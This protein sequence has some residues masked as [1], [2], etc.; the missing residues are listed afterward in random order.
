[1]PVERLKQNRDMLMVAG[2][3]AMLATIADMFRDTVGFS[4]NPIYLVHVLGHI[5]FFCAAFMLGD[6]LIDR[7]LVGRKGTVDVPRQ[8]HA[9]WFDNLCDMAFS[10]IPQTYAF[11]G[12]IKLGVIIYACWAPLLVLLFPGVIWWDTRQQLLQY[13]GLPNALSEGVIT[14]HHPVLDTY[15]YGCFT[16]LGRA[17][18][19]VDAGVYVF[20]LVQAFVTACALACCLILVRRLGGRRDVCV[21]LLAFL[22]LYWH[23]PIYASAMAKDATFLPFFLLFSVASIEVMRSRGQLLRVPGFL[24]V[25]VALLLLVSLTRK[26]GLILVLIVLVVVFFKVTGRRGR[27]VVAAMVVGASLFMTVFMPRAVLP[28][29]GCEPGGKQEV[30]GLMFQQSAL[31]MRDHGDELPEWQR[32]EIERAIGEDGKN[33]YTWFLTDSVKDPTFGKADELDF[34][35]YFGAWV[36]GLLQHPLCYLEAYL[37]VQIGW[38]AMPVAGSEAISPYVTPVDG[39]NVSHVFPRSQD[40]GLSWSDA[41]LGRSVESLVAWFQ[42]T[43][44][45]MLVGSKALWSTWGMAFLLLEIKR[46]APQKLYLMAPLVAANL[47]LWISPTSYT[48]ESM[49]YLLPLLFWLPVSAAMTFASV[50]STE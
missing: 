15:L 41:T 4:C 34:A 22:C 13:S 50:A 5:A 31:L 44:V 16:D 32:Q 28:A 18:G 9:G 10:G 49:R 6:Y 7:F 42:S 48:T 37:G 27:V 26:T 45:G 1:M 29:L 40:L 47:V 35:A 46:R 21:A 33:N 14:D 11:G 20:C 24:A 30:Y 8:D 2:I 43:P 39:H 25:Y 3:L 12:I 19:S 36:T 38:Y 23:L 17:L